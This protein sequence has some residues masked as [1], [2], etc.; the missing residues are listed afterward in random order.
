MLLSGN[1]AFQASGPGI[2]ISKIEGFYQCAKIT[3]GLLKMDGT[4]VFFPF[5]TS[6]F[7][8]EFLGRPDA[9]VLCGV[10]IYG[11]VVSNMF[12]FHPYLGKM[13]PFWLIPTNPNPSLEW[14]FQGSNPILRISQDSPGFLGNILQMGWFNHQP[15]YIVYQK[16]RHIRHAVHN[17]ARCGFTVSRV[18][19][20]NSPDYSCGVVLGLPYQ[21]VGHGVASCCTISGGLCDHSRDFKLCVFSKYNTEDTIETF[22]LFIGSILR[23][24]PMVT[25]WD[26]E[27]DVIEFCST[28]DLILFPGGY[29][30]RHARELVDAGCCLLNSD[31]GILILGACL[32]FQIL[33]IARAQLHG[34]PN[35][36]SQE[37]GWGEAYVQKLEFPHCGLGRTTLF[38]ETI[39]VKVRHSYGVPVCREADGFSCGNFEN[40]HC[41]AFRYQKTLRR[42]FWAQ[43]HLERCGRAHIECIF[44]A[45]GL[46]DLDAA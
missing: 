45:L 42:L 7:C 18:Y 15:I 29:G 11:V 32:G 3:E 43:W 17:V 27:T 35:A 14:F 19:L 33:E 9:R 2:Y 12:Y 6:T 22:R 25:F 20:M 31:N 5:P 4:F 37:F 30:T 41:L 26:Y 13:N 44:N 23:A 24:R 39:Q 8:W 16:F 34:Q 40:P 1:D 36:S 21:C 10:Y 38:G 46:C 28:A